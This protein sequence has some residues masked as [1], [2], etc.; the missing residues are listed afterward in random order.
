LRRVALPH[1]RWPQL[2]LE[3]TNGY[4]DYSVAPSVTGWVLSALESNDRLRRAGLAYLDDALRGR[5]IWE[6]H[7]G[8]YQT[9]LYPAHVA[10][11]SLRKKS[12]LSWVL[13][14][15]TDEGGWCYGSKADG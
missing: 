2:L 8:Y 10:S 6:G 7:A 9:P 15:Q 3:R 11:L 5:A 1:G 13:A 12:V 14:H 4:S